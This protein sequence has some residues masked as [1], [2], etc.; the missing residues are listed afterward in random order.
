MNDSREQQLHSIVH[1]Y[2]QA[3]D[4]GEK[5]DRQAILDAHSDLREELAGYFADASKLDAMA[6]S[7]K[8]AAYG[9]P[10][11]ASPTLGKI[12]YFGDYELL[13]EIARGGMGV[14]YKAKQVSLNRVVALKMILKGE[15]ASE[16][17]VRRFRQEAEAAANLDHPN[18]VPIYEVGEHEGQQYFSMKLIEIAAC[19]VE[20]RELA[21]RLAKVARA[22]HHA[23]QRGILHRDLK[24]SN[25]LIDKEGEPHVADFGLAKKVEGGEASTR[26][27]AIIGTPAYMAP[28]QARAEKSLTT[29]VDVYSLG[30]I[31]YEWLTG[32]PPFRG[33]DPLSTLM[34]VANDEPAKP[35]SLNNE[36]DRDLETI[37][38][39]CLE[40]NPAKRYASAETLAD[41]LDRWQRGEPIQAR[42]ATTSERLRKWCRRRPAAA[43]LFAVSGAALV[44]F[45]A[46]LLWA[47]DREQQRVQSER[48][49]RDQAVD[50]K[51]AADNAKTL[52]QKAESAT[53]DQ[54][55]RFQVRRG[56]EHLDQRDDFFALLWF[57]QALKSESPDSPR[58]EAHRLRLSL[59]LQQLPRLRAYFSDAKEFLTDIAFSTD[60]QRVY[61]VGNHQG[62]RHWDADGGKPL[63]DPMKMET[64]ISWGQYIAD[65]EFVLYESIQQD[66]KQSLS[67]WD[68]KD[69]KL[70]FS[71]E[72][73]KDAAGDRVRLLL[74][75]APHR[76]LKR[77]QRKKEVVYEVLDLRTLK[78]IYPAMK[79]ER[80]LGHPAIGPGGKQIAFLS[81]TRKDSSKLYDLHLYDLS[82]G[83]PVW[84]PILIAESEVFR[85]EQRQVYFSPD[86]KHLLTDL[87]AEY[88]RRVRLWDAATGT[89]L[90]PEIQPASS[91]L[92]EYDPF[93]KKSG[94]FFVEERTVG[95]RA[96]SYQRFGGF[97]AP[98]R[99]PGRLDRFVHAPDGSSL[100]TVSGNTST[101]R[102][103]SGDGNLLGLWSPEGQLL[104][105]Y[106]HL[107]GL[108]KKLRFS[109]DGKQ[110]A[111]L[112]D[113]RQ[114]FVWDMAPRGG[115]LPPELPDTH[116]GNDLAYS[117]DGK[118]VAI[119]TVE[120][121][122]KKAVKAT[123]QVFD[124][125]TGKPFGPV[126]VPH[127][128]ESTTPRGF[129][130]GK[131]AFSPDGKR[132]ATLC[133]G[134]GKPLARYFDIRVW[135]VA[136][137]AQITPPIVGKGFEKT[138]GI[139]PDELAFTPDGRW[140]YARFNDQ[141]N[142]AIYVTRVWDAQTG[143]PFD[144]GVPYDFAAF[145][146]DGSRVLLAQN[147][148]NFMRWMAP[149]NQPTLAH[150]LDV[151]TGQTL[152]P[153]IALPHGWVD[154]AYF[155]RDGE[156]LALATYSLAHRAAHLF[157]VRT[158]LPIAGPL[159]F[160]RIFERSFSPDGRRIVC[161]S[162][163]RVGKVRVFDASTG[164][165][166][167]PII[168]LADECEHVSFAANGLALV[169]RSNKKI[170]I[171]D[172]HT[173]DP[174]ASTILTPDYL[175]NGDRKLTVR[176]PRSTVRFFDL[177]PLDWPA[178]DIVRVSE[179]LAGR[180]IDVFGN[181][182]PL[183]REEVGQR[184]SEFWPR[185]L[186]QLA[187]GSTP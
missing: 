95:L 153:P 169:T 124:S 162:D 165:A 132:L 127:H 47:L 90:T 49:L 18:I 79:L 89:P 125:G 100:A 155:S 84:P 50:A 29:A 6:K 176:T 61:S 160:D 174:L 171:W 146:A 135:D 129:L 117:A 36:I 161:A 183:T 9:E 99:P 75:P 46:G 13:E 87:D 180:R 25:I 66:D 72:Q 102:T 70:V 164:A 69:G 35:R 159:P 14:V 62:L 98:I 31:L 7:L 118:W 157:D 170:Q 185:Y 88:R 45:V 17:D 82:T 120:W 97:G 53:R 37:C 148:G 58:Q 91:G 93:S 173:G 42:P 55:V 67:L 83:K 52:A 147:E 78:P 57:A 142:H 23:H 122:K 130:P 141:P 92:Y 19:G 48:H 111:C 80:D 101:W 56:I 54:V 33:E 34:Q 59:L 115:T 94:S 116:E 65:G 28:E 5:P 134:R 182:L 12:R 179:L 68:A 186:K 113:H 104:Q 154:R 187:K 131:V 156:R 121:S 85:Q 22:V 96:C 10:N 76:W 137:G 139:F 178:D 26:T 109:P 123:V 172:S 32:R 74:T 163:D 177:N 167:S 136:T 2:L 126:I 114:V 144:P 119:G 181:L 138:V 20:P 16:I 38:L 63:G 3:R 149:K 112:D 107:P 158:G 24:P 151:R 106:L 11:V 21:Q 30:A 43:A 51:D 108:S 71:E 143:K 184:W 103:T 110:L 145:S 40:K 150:I 175:Q 105:P 64:K 44:L 27:G 166:L 60:G 168:L 133:E 4:R 81:E 73:V 128:P 8:T 39:K 152:G 15:L 1:A 41:D 86:G 77:T 140:I